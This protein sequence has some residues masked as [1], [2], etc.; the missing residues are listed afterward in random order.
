MEKI[1]GGIKHDCYPLTPAQMVHMYTLQLSPTHEI[2]NIGTGTFLKTDLNISVLR[3]ALNR[4]IERCEAMRLRIW[5]D[6]ETNEDWQ[7]VVPYKNQYF[8][9][10]VYP[11]WKDR[12]ILE[13]E[14]RE[15]DEAIDFPEEIRII[16]EVTDDP[17]FKNAALARRRS[18]R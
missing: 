14:L 16:R 4:A 18:K 2:V 5:K 12:A 13:I 11:F 6:P 10:D 17:S 15:E 1:I 9:I 3:E 8:E 7:Y